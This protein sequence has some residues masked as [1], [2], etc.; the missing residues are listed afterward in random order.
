[1][2]PLQGRDSFP[3]KLPNIISNTSC[4]PLIKSALKT[5]QITPNDIDCLCYTRGP[6]MESPLQVAAVVVQMIA[7][8]EG[9]YRIFGE[10]IDIAVGNCLDRFARVLTLCNDPNPGYNIEQLDF[11]ILSPPAF[12][13]D[14][15]HT[16]TTANEA[17]RLLDNFLNL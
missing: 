14:K 5:A 17:L 1:M 9:R 7:Y 11:G 10:T 2:L 12:S 3:K 13:E 16:K 15:R 6:G 4:R 8:S